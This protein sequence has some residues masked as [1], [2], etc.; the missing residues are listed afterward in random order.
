MNVPLTVTDVVQPRAYGADR[1]ARPRRQQNGRA[2]RAVLDRARGCGDRLRGAARN[3]RGGSR[4]QHQPAAPSAVDRSARYRRA[5]DRR[6]RARQPP[7]PA[8]LFL[9]RWKQPTI[10]RLRRVTLVSSRRLDADVDTCMRTR[11]PRRSRSRRSRRSPP[12]SPPEPS[13]R[14]PPPPP[15][16]PATPAHGQRGSA[17]RDVGADDDSCRSWSIHPSAPTFQTSGVIT[18]TIGRGTVLGAARRAADRRR[19]SRRRSAVRVRP[20]DVVITGINTQ[21]SEGVSHVANFGPGITV[22]SATPQ[23]DTHLLVRL[24]IA[25]N[26]ESRPALV[27]VS[28]GR[29]GAARQRLQHRLRHRHHHGTPAECAGPADRERAGVPAADDDLRDDRR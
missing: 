20:L 11:R 19:P 9:S 5:D 28:T 7:R 12:S 22:S 13:S 6:A 23:D 4:G 26:A 21:F 8:P 27:A 16:L 10:A 25:G 24:A 2:I 14:S 17:R 29:S 1:A 15:T 18:G 3:H